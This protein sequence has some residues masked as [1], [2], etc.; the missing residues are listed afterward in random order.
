M[1]EIF[2]A[3]IIGGGIMGCATAYE[4]AQRG[5][6]IALLEKKSI[7][8]GPSGQSSAIVRQHYSNEL[9]AR[10]AKYSLGI[11]QN[12]DQ[13]IGGECG[14]RRVG[15]LLLVDAKDRAGL[16]ANIA[17]QQR[18]GIQTSLVNTETVH[19]LM[20]GLDVA[21][22]LV[23][24]YE[25]ESGYADPY[26]TVTAYAQAARRL[27][28]RVYP[29][30]TVTGIR[31]QGGRVQGVESTRGG[32][33]APLVLNCTGAWGAQVARLAGV[34]VPI[35]SCRVQVSIFKRPAGEEAAHPV[36]G[37]FNQAVYFRPETGN[38]TLV[39]L[40]DPEEAKAI[41]DPDHYPTGVDDA[42]VLDSGERLV[43]RYPAMVRGQSRGGYASLYAI[44]PDWHPIVDELPA[45]SGLFICSGFSGHGF[46]LGPSVGRMLADLVLDVPDPLF[47]AHL[48]RSGRFAANEPV[49][50]QYEY[51][52][53]G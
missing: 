15:F 53:V 19:E 24:A 40:I 46:K 39:G 31:L 5:L 41:V 36:V 11:F 37:D 33:D 25:P 35:N 1:N 13:T 22:Q 14:F 48:F 17:L 30:T 10:M 18:V 28:V 23:A 7:G 49:R 50:G 32:Y 38:L 45:G 51:S 44:T 34:E 47:G 43:A 9:T 12:F 29:N 26:L 2:D 4:L 8:A 42:F 52:I 6:R 3:L 16:A 27:G 20:P 21:D